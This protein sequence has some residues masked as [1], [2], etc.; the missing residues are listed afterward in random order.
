[1]LRKAENN[2]KVV[3]GVR[4]NLSFFEKKVCLMKE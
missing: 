4:K 3:E 1:M 2:K